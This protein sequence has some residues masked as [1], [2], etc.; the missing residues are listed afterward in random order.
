[1]KNA[2][3]I[4][5][6][7]LVVVFMFGASTSTAGEMPEIDVRFFKKDD[8]DIKCELH[9][10]PLT[11]APCLIGCPLPCLQRSI[12]PECSFAFVI[13]PDPDKVKDLVGPIEY[14]DVGQNNQAN[15]EL[16]IEEI[17]PFIFV[18]RD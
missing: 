12:Y 3:Q 14:V 5:M 7:G 1:M 6:L 10:D 2:K 15:Q 11:L 9:R 17:L 16:S 18:L 13:P 8:C 4:V